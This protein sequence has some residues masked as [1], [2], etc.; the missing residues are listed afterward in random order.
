MTLLPE[1]IEKITVAMSGGVDSSV[2]AWLL[3]KKGHDVH[4]VFMKLI[5]PNMDEQTDRVRQVAARLDIPLDCIDLSKEFEQ[6]VLSYFKS[7]YFAG[8]TPNPC[9]V[10]NPEIKFG[11]LLDRVASEAGSMLATGHYARVEHAPGAM[12]RLFKGMDR[13]KDQSYFLCRLQQKQ[14]QRICFPLGEY[15]KEEVYEMAAESGIAPLHAG[16]SQD[17]CFLEDGSVSDFLKSYA[18]EG[19]EGPIV[20]VAGRKLGNHTGIHG[21]TIG[22][23]RGLGIPDAT[24]YYVVGLDPEA[25]RVIVGKDADLWKSS[26]LAGGFVWTAGVQPELPQE[27]EVKIRYRHQAAPAVVTATASGE[28]HVRFSEP[29]RAITPGQFAVLYRGDELVGGG[30]ILSSLEVTIEV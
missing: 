16:E 5:S 28:I 29:Q 10:C 4:G 22:Q 12:V 8:K 23:R 1:N 9:V 17:V 6:E 30:E 11:R 3:K 13:K 27:F 25:N 19:R 14:L 26:L 2:A 20:S 21:Y 24:P 7:S 15:R 18:P